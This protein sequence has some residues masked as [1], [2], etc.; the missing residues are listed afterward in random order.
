MTGVE[1]ILAGGAATA[2]VTETDIGAGGRA[3]TV[4]AQASATT[5]PTSVQPRNRLTMKMA[6]AFFLLRPMIEG[7]KYSKRAQNR[8]K[9]TGNSMVSS[10]GRRTYFFAL[11]F[12][13]FFLSHSA[14]IL[15][16]MPGDGNAGL[17]P[18]WLAVLSNG[19]G[20]NTKSLFPRRQAC[21]R[22]SKVLRCGIN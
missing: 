4:K 14:M 7:R 3:S 18:K 2:V 9:A 22:S 1:S 20:R 17:S 6:V 10:C 13:F 19:F 21:F 11:P 8:K 16:T 5:Q 15:R 12:G